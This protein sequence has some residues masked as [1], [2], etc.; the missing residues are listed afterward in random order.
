[1]ILYKYYNAQDEYT[2]ENITKNQ[3]H[4]SDVDSF[5]DLNDSNLIIFNKLDNSEIYNNRLQHIRV[6]CFSTDLSKYMWEHYANNGNGFCIG[7]KDDELHKI[8]KDII[9]VQYGS[10]DNIKKILNNKLQEY[11]NSGFDKKYGLVLLITAFSLKEKQFENER[12]MRLLSKEENHTGIKPSCI[13]IGDKVKEDSRK[14]VIEY[15]KR[16]DIKLIL[17]NHLQTNL[18]TT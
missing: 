16:D 3:I 18:F 7:Y 11:I 17:Q 5:D 10:E 2:I 13:Y 9:K 6:S 8:S 15:C 14:K 1:M 12:E 4:F